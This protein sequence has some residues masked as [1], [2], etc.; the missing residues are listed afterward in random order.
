[1]NS[2][3]KPALLRILGV[4]FGIAAVVGATIGGGIL[5]VPGTVA[6]LVPE[7][8]LL[9]ALWAVAGIYGIV[10][11][12]CFAELATALP[13]AGGSLVYVDRTIGRY[14]GFAVGWCDWLLNVVGA[15]APAVPPAAMAT[16]LP[17]TAVGVVIALQMIRETYSG[18]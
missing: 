1:M 10:A 15:G 4:A 9:L 17:V 8:A 11:A 16:L 6:T 3:T 2:T 13:A 18:W 12:S 7:P 5:R 14:P